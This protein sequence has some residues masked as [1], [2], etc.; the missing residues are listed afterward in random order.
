M[1]LDYKSCE[2]MAEELNGIVQQKYPG[3]STILEVSEDG[4]NGTTILFPAS[5]TKTE[6]QAGFG[7]YEEMIS[8]SSNA[9]AN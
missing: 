8:Q 3:R 7:T 2:M 1:K 6:K 5:G 4:E 9:G